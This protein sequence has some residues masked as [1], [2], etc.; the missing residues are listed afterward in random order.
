RLAAIFP[1][2]GDPIRSVHGTGAY[3]CIFSIGLDRRDG[4]P[5]PPERWDDCR[6]TEFKDGR[7]SISVKSKEVFAARTIS[8][9]TQRRNVFEAAERV[10]VRTEDY[11]LRVLGLADQAGIQT[12]EGRLLLEVL[13]RGGKLN[14]RGDDKDLLRLASARGWGSTAT[15]FS[16][17]QAVGCG[18]PCSSARRAEWAIMVV[19]ASLRL[20]L[21]LMLARLHLGVPAS[22]TWRNLDGAGG[23]S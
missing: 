10:G 6:F 8:E 17:A 13:R 22:R 1:I 15:R 18:S 20:H 12:S 2:A 7:I 5:S 16:S 21:H 11:D 3:R 23:R 14:R 19:H 4:F 9:E